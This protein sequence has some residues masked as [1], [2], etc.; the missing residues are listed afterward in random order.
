MIRTFFLNARHRTTSAHCFPVPCADLHRLVTYL[1][2]EDSVK[3]LL[4]WV[5]SGLDDLD[6]QAE[7]AED[8]A[9]SQALKSTEAYP[10]FKAGNPSSGVGPVMPSAGSLD[11]T[12][13][14]DDGKSSL[15]DTHPG[16]GIG[17][18]QG[19]GSQE[20]DEAGEVQRAR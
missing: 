20:A 9:Y 17:L 3:S 6:T 7:E 18:G 12:A 13:E 1:S 15:D 11:S 2:R 8:L 19:L 14:E 10:P 5:T 16:L 4:S